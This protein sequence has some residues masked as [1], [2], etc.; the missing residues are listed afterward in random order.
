MNSEVPNYYTS[1]LPFRELF[2]Q[3]NPILTYHKIGRRPV[4]TKL[5]GLYVSA[6]L[7]RRQL[8]ELR[9]AG[10]TSGALEDCSGAQERR[11]VITFDDGY[12]NVLENAVAPLADM[13]FKAVQ[14]LVADLV[15][16]NNAWDLPRGEAPEP[17]MD[18]AQI[19]D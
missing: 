5:K 2:A 13:K 16:K 1:L 12:V 4:R 19:R 7:F 3:G 11:L 8:E 9:A 17:L 18:A 14:F 15:G 6:E 10:F